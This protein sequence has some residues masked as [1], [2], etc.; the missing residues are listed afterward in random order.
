M[1]GSG[2]AIIKTEDLKG[3]CGKQKKKISLDFTIVGRR[4]FEEIMLSVRVGR[5]VSGSVVTKATVAPRR[6]YS[7]GNAPST[8]PFCLLFFSLV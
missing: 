7:T 3:Q 2:K 1:T 8:S 5:L 4:R 6:A